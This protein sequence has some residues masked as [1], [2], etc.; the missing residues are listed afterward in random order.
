RDGSEIA[1]HGSAGRVQ[2]QG[3]AWP[4]QPMQWEVRREPPAQHAQGQDDAEPDPQPVWRSGVRFRFA[5]LGEVAATVT[6]VGEQVHIQM[7]TGS[8][9]SATTLRAYA[10][11]L[12]QAMAAAGVAL[13]AL[14]IA[15]DSGAGD[16]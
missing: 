14:T 13:T 7:Q 1:R 11:Q 16:D 9:A 2:W 3:Q 10:G 5:L 12:E 6:L 4:G 8:D 15:P